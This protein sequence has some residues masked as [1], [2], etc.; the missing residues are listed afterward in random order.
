MRSEELHASGEGKDASWRSA[1]LLLGW[2][3]T[4]G[5]LR[6]GY[7]GLDI[8]HFS[9]E[10]CEARVELGK[11]GAAGGVELREKV[12]HLL[13]AAADHIELLAIVPIGLD[14]LLDEIGC[15]RRRQSTAR[16]GLQRKM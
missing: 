12:R 2:F 11:A 8:I 15:A 6:L 5:A 10:D 3:L 16:H 13:D 1:L 9:F 4:R 7:L 14:L